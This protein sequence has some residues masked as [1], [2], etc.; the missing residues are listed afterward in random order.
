M[1]TKLTGIV[2]GYVAYEGKTIAYEVKVSGSYYFSKGRMYMPNGDP[3]YP[4]DEEYDG[5]FFE[6]ITDYTIYDD[7]G[8]DCTTKLTEQGELVIQKDVEDNKEWDDVSWDEPN[9]PEPPE[10]PED[11]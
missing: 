4:D 2:S 5:P 8:N 10:P 7:E 9:Y 11:D 1:E 6:E 3:G